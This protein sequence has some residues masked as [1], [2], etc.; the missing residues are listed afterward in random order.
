M[1]RKA[2]I[3]I[4]DS[5]LKL[6]RTEYGFSQERMAVIIGLSK[7]TLVDI[8][9]ERRSLGWT[10][11]VALCQLFPDSEVIAGVFGGNPTDMVL[12]LAF[13]G[14]EQPRYHR[15]FGGRIWWTV[16]YENDDFS[17]QQNI[18][19][20]HYRLLTKDGRRIASSFQIDDLLPLFANANKKGEDHA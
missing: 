10:G 14:G 3:S 12:A 15:T 9:K 7:K 11:S 1:D 20:Q 2:F 16:L 4:C 13:E 8:E 19:S 6:V 18:I 5:K 17:I